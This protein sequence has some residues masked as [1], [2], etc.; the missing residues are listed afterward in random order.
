[1]GNKKPVSRGQGRRAVSRARLR[2]MID[3]AIV[4]AHDES[5]QIAGIYAAIDEHLAVPFKATLLGMPVAVSGVTLNERDEIVAICTRGRF[6][7]AIHLLD[8]VL[9]SPRPAGAEWIEAYR[10]WARGG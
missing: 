5:E 3:E 4:D 10:L 6:S 9:P 1:M 8:L 2:E 7:Q